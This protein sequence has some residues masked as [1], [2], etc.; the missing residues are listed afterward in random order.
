MEEY[1]LSKVIEDIEID[2]REMNIIN[3][4]KKLFFSFYMSGL[5]DSIKHK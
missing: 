2:N 3:Q 5:I 1:I 4:N